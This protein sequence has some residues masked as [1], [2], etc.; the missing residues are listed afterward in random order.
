MA[1]EAEGVIVSIFPEQQVSDKFKKREFV[2]EQREN[3]NGYE[4]NE[5]IKFQMTQ[6]RCNLID[7]FQEGQRIKVS[8]NLKGRKWEKDGQTNYFTNLEAWRIENANEGTT[9]AAQ[10]EVDSFSADESQDFGNDLPF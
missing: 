1:Y 9:D 7:P 8:F 5:F 2:I 6:D 3:R 4:F 10:P